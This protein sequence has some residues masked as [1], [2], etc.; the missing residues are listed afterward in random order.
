MTRI[1]PFFIQDN[2]E[3]FVSLMMAY[4]FNSMTHLAI[5]VR[6]MAFKFLELV[7]QSYP[8]SFFLYAEKVSKTAVKCYVML[9]LGSLLDV[10]FGS[11]QLENYCLCSSLIGKYSLFP[12]SG[13]IM[14]FCTF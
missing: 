6:L 13:S 11:K 4:I 9:L 10:L 12:R 8:P 3:L 2:Q 1:V 5:D 7:V 14:S